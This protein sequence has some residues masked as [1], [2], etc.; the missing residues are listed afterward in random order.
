MP[1]KISP[2]LLRLDLHGKTQYQAQIAIN[3]ILRRQRGLYR[4]ILVHG[5][6][7]GVALREMVRREYAA[8]PQVRRLVAL[9]DNE[10]ELV[11]REF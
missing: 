11:L 5:S 9:N 7:H 3:A 1:E 2:G 8:H 6:H 4:L 10:T